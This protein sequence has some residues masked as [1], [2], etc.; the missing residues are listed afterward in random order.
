MPVCTAILLLLK[1]A[2][3]YGIPN[4]YLEERFDDG[5]GWKN[6]WVQSKHRS[7]YGLFTISHGKFYGDAQVGIGLQTT[8]N[9]RFY[10]A[11]RKFDIMPENL[12]GPLVIQ[13]SVKHEQ[14]IDCGGAYIKILSG[15]INQTD[16]HNSSSYY[17]MFGPDICAD[18]K[19]LQMILRYNDTYFTWAHRV[20]CK[21]DRLTH[22]YTLVIHQN[23]TY[24][25][26]IDLK[27]VK[28]G[29]LLED[30]QFLVPASKS[31]GKTDVVDE[32][33]GT[34]TEDP[35]IRSTQVEGYTDEFLSYDSTNKKARPDKFNRQVKDIL[36]R[37]KKVRPSTCSKDS[38]TQIVKPTHMD[39]NFY[40]GIGAVGIDVWQV[41]AGT[42]FDNILITD[43]ESYAIRFAKKTWQLY[44]YPEKHMK[45]KLH[46]EE[47]IEQDREQARKWKLN[48]A[49]DGKEREKEKGEYATSRNKELGDETS[50]IT[51]EDTRDS[52]V[53]KGAPLLAK[54][55]AMLDQMCSSPP[56][57][58]KM[59][60]D[61]WSKVL[62]ENELVDRMGQ[63]SGILGLSENIVVR[64]VESYSVEGQQKIRRAGAKR[65]RWAARKSHRCNRSDSQKTR[66]QNLNKRNRNV[67]IMPKFEQR[68]DEPLES[69][70]KRLAD[71]LKER[72][73]KLLSEVVEM[74][75]REG[76]VR[77]YEATAKLENEGGMMTKDGSRRRLPGG[78]F[79]Q[80]AKEDSEAG[81][82]VKQLFKKDRLEKRSLRRKLGLAVTVDKQVESDL[83]VRMVVWLLTR[84]STA[85]LL[86]FLSVTFFAFVAS[87]D[88]NVYL[89]ERFDDG[90]AWKNRWVQ[91]SH[92]ANYGRFKRTYGRYFANWRNNMGIQTSQNARFYA[93]SRKLDTV[94][95]SRNKTFVLQYSVKHEQNI[96]CGGA[97]IK[98]LS[99]ETD[100]N[101][102]NGLTPYYV[103]FGPDICGYERKVHV[104]FGYKGKNLEL[105]RELH[106]EPD[107]LTHVY[108]LMLF[109]N[110]TYK[111]SID[112][113]VVSQGNLE[114]HWSFLPPKF[115][116]D[117]KAK[118][119]DDW[120][121]RKT[122][123]DV[124]DTKPDDWD[125]PKT[126]LDP[127]AVKPD[128]WND[129][130]N[131]EWRPPEIPNP[132]YKG[133]WKPR[134]IK[135]P[136]YQGVWSAPYI[137]NPE[138]VADP[139]LVAHADVG[140]VGFEMWQ[141][142]CGTIF[143][144]I[145]ITDDPQFAEKVANETWRAYID[146][147]KLRLNEYLEKKGKS[148]EK[149][150]E[151]ENQNLKNAED[152][153]ELRVEGGQAVAND[154]L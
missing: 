44:K 138:Y 140:A 114:D 45:E 106:F 136:N 3:T 150:D 154:E 123:I 50:S 87:G 144:N 96:E 59:R 68:A 117:P 36:N 109:P 61:A 69:F 33:E 21:S 63:T 38:E 19:V 53:D 93:L 120:D 133:E 16:F 80:L 60:F 151:S 84:A 34:S 127:N 15:K 108:T 143:D 14:K 152:G 147:E 122:I 77:L 118:Q 132:E 24:K 55:E 52:N 103:M 41:K 64:D 17:I 86:P 49:S 101:D 149:A 70:V 67:G 105:D 115:I 83:A 112:Q 54:R 73:I 23:L 145:L 139:Y 153:D 121:S 48:F 78:I 98:V 7:D 142:K 76:A 66:E 1:V 62:I 137:Y 32:E 28:S 8:Q 58:K 110:M 89:Y 124:N 102:F 27:I 12:S 11:S 40:K 130:I 42:I 95:D 90:D 18:S 22:V 5:V 65:R 25:V 13:F 141:M 4:I 131:G 30:L 116:K 81:D 97:Y 2:L 128:D 148:K 31:E 119:P 85:T 57:K 129:E 94:F 92:S 39:L 9:S 29:L 111:V 35:A 72:E 88:P 43:D 82:K 47:E 146:L 74:V 75:G 79:M 6:R 26:L 100:L 107:N 134:E 51:E 10:A 56:A 113:S 104:I 126:I 125:K 46:E 135:N 20:N 37:E 99:A 71:C 91:S